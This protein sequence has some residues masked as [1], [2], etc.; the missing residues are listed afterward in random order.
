MSYVAHL[1]EQ[2][3]RSKSGSGLSAFLLK[4]HKKWEN[5]GQNTFKTLP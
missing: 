4:R 3:S 1:R 2:W 5:L